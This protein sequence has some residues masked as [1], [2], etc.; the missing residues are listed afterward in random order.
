MNVHHLLRIH[1]LKLKLFVEID[2]IRLQRL[3]PAVQEDVD[4]RIGKCD[5]T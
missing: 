1:E 2:G 5:P 3:K 4:G